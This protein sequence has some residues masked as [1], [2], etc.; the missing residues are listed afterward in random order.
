MRIISAV[1]LMMFIMSG[2]CLAAPDVAP[3]DQATVTAST[4]TVAKPKV[5]VL[6]IGRASY[7][8]RPDVWGILNLES[9][10][11]F[12]VALARK[13]P[14]ADVLP[15][16]Q[17]VDVL[18]KLTQAELNSVGLDNTQMQQLIKTLGADY[19]VVYRDAPGFW[20]KDLDV[21]FSPQVLTYS[22]DGLLSDKTFTLI[23]KK[24][25]FT[26]K[27][28]PAFA[29]RLYAALGDHVAGTGVIK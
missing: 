21:S 8:K 17:N 11:Q 13:L 15:F 29:Q 25:D 4:A 14:N 5:A 2:V 18:I 3:A 26:D 1:L 9:Y 24:K 12:Q 7:N 23:V 27:Q 22:R 10:E 19:A 6:C 20:T 16:T 28:Y